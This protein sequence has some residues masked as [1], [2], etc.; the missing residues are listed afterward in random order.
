[1]H[2]TLAAF[3]AG[4][5][6][7][8]SGGVFAGKDSDLGK[9]FGK[10]TV[11]DAIDGSK[12]GKK[13]M[14]AKG[15]WQVSDGAI[16]GKELAADKH[17]AVLNFAQPNKDSAIRFSFKLAGAKGF[18]LSYNKAQGHLFRVAVA[19][20]GLTITLDKDKKDKA[21]KVIKLGGATGRF[22]QGEWYT[23]LVVVEGEN[24]SVQTDNGV[25]ATG[26]HATLK[27]PKPNYRFVMRGEALVLDDVKIWE[28]K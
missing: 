16:H 27:Q 2:K 10:A 26:R 14:V 23:M 1:M 11:S 28:L 25:K 8:S 5:F 22:K 6:A 19:E 17:A 4:V 12:L 9:E 7:L 3:T 20:N 15:D 18:N 13:W 21:S 24:V